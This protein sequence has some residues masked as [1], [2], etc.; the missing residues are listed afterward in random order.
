MP[1][2]LFIIKHN[3]DKTDADYFKK[4]L[5]NFNLKP[6][7]VVYFENNLDAV[8]SAESVGI[9]SFF[10]GADKKDQWL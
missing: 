6:E 2:P 9:K 7:D 8:K 10:C 4:M 3:L 5:T 1:Y